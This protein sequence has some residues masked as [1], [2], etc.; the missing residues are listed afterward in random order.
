MEEPNYKQILTNLLASGF[1][2]DHKGD[3]YEDY[4]EAARQARFVDEEE[5]RLNISQ[6]SE[7]LVK[8][9]NATTLYNLELEFID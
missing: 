9:Q 5:G 1:L 7:H 2:C 3:F 6:L 8:T 4:H